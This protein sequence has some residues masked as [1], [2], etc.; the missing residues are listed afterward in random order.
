MTEPKPSNGRRQYLVT[1]SQLDETIF[2]TR[3][4]FG[5]MLEREFNR[6]T[7]SVHVSHW[8]CCREDREAE[9]SH[10]HC[11][12]K[13]SG[14]KKWVRVKQ[15]IQDIYGISVNFS[16][17]HDYYLS[18][19]RYVMKEDKHVY[20]SENH[21]NLADAQS[22]M[23]KRSIAANK[24]KSNQSA[25]S[26]SSS[27]KASAPHPT[28]KKRIRLTNP[29]VGMF[30]RQHNIHTY[31]ELLATAD[32]RYEN[33]LSDLSDFVYNYKEESLRAQI[34]KAWDMAD[35]RKE[36][37]AAKNRDRLDILIKAKTE[38]ECICEGKWLTCAKEVL[39]LNNINEA[40]FTKAIYD[41][42]RYG[43][44]KFRNVLIAGE[45][46]RAKTFI[47]KPMKKIYGERDFFENPASHKFGWGGC[48]NKTVIVLQDFRWSS[49]IITWK[50]FLLLL[51]GETVKLPAPRNFYRDDVCIS[52]DVAIFATSIDEIKY[53]GT[54][55]THDDQEDEMMKSRWKV[56]HFYHHFK[57]EHQVKVKPC[58]FCFA[59]FILP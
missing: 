48:E 13:L 58:G 21:P 59:T 31:K 1:Y 55:N 23:T 40:E 8:A 25:T 54:Y 44:G 26:S 15:N 38:G 51:E 42:L 53:K 22:P 11:A 2:P 18:A 6:G 17:S 56:F 7:S 29:E 34:Q 20:H 32:D 24:R 28:A 49:E 16:D 57:E 39:K 43:R 19:Y 41:N 47:L 14:V 27:E 10:Y 30:I 33:G 36:V 35:A 52:G 45:T 4:S 46:N 3:R 12:L 50:D 9:G 5:N 37:E